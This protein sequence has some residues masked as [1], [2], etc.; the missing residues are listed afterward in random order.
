MDTGVYTSWCRYLAG[1]LMVAA[2]A[3]YHGSVT[4]VHSFVCLCLSGT[5]WPS[6]SSCVS[7]RAGRGIPYKLTVWPWKREPIL[8]LM[9]WDKCDVCSFARTVCEC[10]C[11][12]VQ[13][14]G[15]IC[16]VLRLWRKLHVFGSVH[17]R[18]SVYVH[19][20]TKG[21]VGRVLS[22]GKCCVFNL[23]PRGGRAAA[24]VGLLR[25]R[26]SVNSTFPSWTQVLPS[27]HKQMSS[28][29]KCKTSPLFLQL[30]ILIHLLCP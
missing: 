18:V 17:S 12:S 3:A 27:Q 7:V 15:F 28:F 16:A 30:S 4:C 5:L 26:V 29:I 23:S 24:G 13:G 9:V 2:P 19:S 6:L 21:C 11:V 14:W 25:S 20:V 1:W 10:V 22:G 8:M